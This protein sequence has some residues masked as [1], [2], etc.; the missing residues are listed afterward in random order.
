MVFVSIT[1]LAIIIYTVWLKFFGKH[2]RNKNYR[3]LLG[4]FLSV[5]IA[6]ILY[7]I[8]VV[9]TIY[10]M[11]KEKH[12]EFETKEWI[13]IGEDMN[14]RLSRFQMVDDLID[15]KILIE[16]DSLALK[17]ILGEP[18]W[19]QEKDNKWIYEAGTGGGFGFVDHYLDIYFGTGNKVIRT[20]HR[21]IED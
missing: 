12:R 16:K 7:A 19:R 2:V 13:L 5:S 10:Y 20:E 14:K 17:K 3:T 21:R 1:F 18:T 4:L 11:T 6:L 15:R 9:G 8:F